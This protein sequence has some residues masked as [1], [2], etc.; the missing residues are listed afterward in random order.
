MKIKMIISKN[1]IKLIANFR[2]YFHFLLTHKR[3]L[4]FI[5]AIYF[6]AL[7][8]L[9]LANFNYID[10]NERNIFGHYE[11]NI[12]SRYSASIFSGIL[13]LNP[14]F[15]LTLFPLTLFISILFL[16]L[17]SLILIK[18]INKDLLDKKI[19]L[20]ASI[21]V[22]LSPYYLENLSYKFDSP[23]MSLSILV[24]IIPFLFIRNNRNFIIV[25]TICLLIMI[26][27]YQASSGIYIMLTLFLVFKGILNKNYKKAF[28]LCI[29]AII[30]YIICLIIFKSIHNPILSYAASDVLPINYFIDGVIKNITTYFSLFLEDLGGG[31]RYY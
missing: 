23:F 14:K 31:L 22:G 30:S 4:I 9:I 8:S 7:F 10:D 13:S 26:T 17:S 12:W 3:N 18:I 11:F 28:Y 19:A 25:S 24:S 21:A 2:Y 5:Y 29:S 1:D 27:S 6:I 15:L 20:F 16:S